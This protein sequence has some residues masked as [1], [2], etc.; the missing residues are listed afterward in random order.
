VENKTG[1]ELDATDFKQQPHKNK[2]GKDYPANAGTD[3][4]RY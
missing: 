2:Y 4:E 1:I 3:D